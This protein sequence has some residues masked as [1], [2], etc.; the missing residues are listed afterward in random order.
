MISPSNPVTSA[1]VSAS[2]RIDISD[3]GAEI[4]G[5]GSVVPL[6][7]EREPLDAVVDE[8]ELAR[9]CAVA[10]EHDLAS[11]RFDSIILRIKRGITCAFSG[12][13]LSRGP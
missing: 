3:A 12:S 7:R 11:P 10:P 8:E 1:I 5:L 9:R 6:G 13:K 2:S 4:H